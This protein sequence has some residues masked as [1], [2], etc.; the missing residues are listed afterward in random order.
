MR[1][2]P[3]EHSS[4]PTHDIR[5]NYPKNDYYNVW[6]GQRSVQIEST[7]FEETHDKQLLRLG[8]KASSHLSLAPGYHRIFA[9]DDHNIRLGPVIGIIT[10]R[11]QAGIY[12]RGKN[13]KLFKELFREAARR[14]MILYQFYPE[15][16]CLRRKHIRGHSLNLNGQYYN[17]TF[18][19]PDVVY[20]RIR[21]RNIEQNP[22]VKHI[23]TSFMK[24]PRIHL[25]NSRFINKLE[26]YR[27]L[28]RN[29]E[30]CHV[31]PETAVLNNRSLKY[32]LG[33]YGSAF[34]KPIANSRGKGIVKISKTDQKIF[35]VHHANQNHAQKTMSFSEVQLKLKR[36]RIKEMK[37][38]VQKAIPLAI[39]KGRTFDL[40]AQVQKD[41]NGNWM[42]TGVGV[43]LA[44]LN[45]IVT[46]IPNGGTAK[47]YKP[48]IDEVFASSRDIREAIDEQL[49]MITCLVPRAL[50]KELGI[51]LGILSIDIGIDRKGK[52]WLI[53]VNSK[54][55]SFDEDSIREVHT[56]TLVDYFLYSAKNITG[57]KG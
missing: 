23:L 17:A 16:V 2:D 45:R 32:F 30:T 7:V 12:P 54:P 38:I 26:V 18:P 43:R 22:D 49:K 31:I 34:I 35:T 9:K 56:R 33:K 11:D 51:E 1:Q 36:A 46:H 4:T 3:H 47:A 24:D 20:N 25:F 19:F 42:L 15:G 39:Y 29:P 14:G 40:R 50:E 28:R 44:G 10:S 48:V 6:A 37:Y 27:V 41:G 21:Y 5:T 57:R 53:E 52:L 8:S 13:A 55:A